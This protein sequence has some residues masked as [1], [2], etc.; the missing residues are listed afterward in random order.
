MAGYDI[1]PRIGIKGESEFN[2]QIKKI[3]NSLKE[4]G[5][6]M[7]ALTAEFES[8]E[9]SQ[10]ALIAKSKV[11]QKQLDAQGQKMAVLQSQYDKEVAKLRELGDEYSRLKAEMGE[12]SAEAGKA[13]AAFNKQAES[14]SKL[15][16]A[17]N[18]TQGFMNKLNNA[19]NKNGQMLNEIETGARDAATGLSTMSDAAQDA[20]SG[21][22]S[23]DSKLDMSNIMQASEVLSG[24]GDTLKEIGSEAIGA[25]TDWDGATAKMQAN[26][27]LTA[28]E[29]EN[30]QGVAQQVFEQGIAS[31]IDTAS[32][33]VMLVKQNFQDLSN[34]D[35]SNLS[36]QL[37]A[38]SERTGTDLQE[39]MRGVDQIMTAF[40]VDGQQAMDLI[41]AGYQQNLNSSGDFMDTL[42]EYAPLFSEAGFSAEQM[43]AVLDSGMENGALNTDKVADAV[44]EL[45]IRFG[46]GTFEQNMGLFSQSTQNMFR[47]WQNGG[48]TVAEVAASI[49]E[50]LKKMTPT[51]QQQALSALSTQ[52]EDLGVDASVALLSASDGF[53]DATGKAN[54]FS[55]ATDS[56]KWQ[57]NLN[58]ITDSL[59]DIGGTVQNTLNPVLEF[60]AGLVEAFSNLPAPV[61]TVLTVL[62]GLVTIFTTL[63]PFISSVLTVIQTLAPIITGTMIPAIGGILSALAPLLPVIAAVVAAVTAAILIFKNWG[64]ITE[65]LSGLW[66]VFKA[67]IS[68][69]WNSIKDTASS[70]W[71]SITSAISN[72]VTTVSQT[73]SN[74]WNNIKTTVS[75]I[76]NNIKDAAVNG[77]RNLVNGIKSVLSGISNTIKGAFDSAISFITSLPG[78]ALGWGRD[79]INGLKNGIMSGVNAIVNA[80]K[81]VANRIR[82]F[83][84]FSRPDEGPLRDYETWM[85]DMLTGMA[86]SVYK[87]LDI[88]QNAA[89]TISGTINSNITDDRNGVMRSAQTSYSSTIV[90]EGDSIILDGKVIG[91]T[92][93][94]YIS[95]GQVARMKARGAFA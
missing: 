15:Q 14:V 94:R 9:N 76:T 78:K 93:E 55:Q 54:E 50:D 36:G 84:H 79:F 73:I 64:T 3:N 77:F 57:G 8:N 20:G 47:E 72:A 6:E 70:V 33:A 37:A 45:Q 40:G 31:S 68:E 7:K 74:I 17:M 30:L 21:L 80:V 62:G 52:F 12:N 39:N 13:E 5:S 82:S 49:G 1:G 34:A 22:E 53:V 69:I 35:L 38:I 4:Y 10:Q 88:I 63:A 46:D 81:N 16:V 92:A 65:F 28:D 32:E 87:N 71:N 85:P 23:I 26:L 89:K 51:E 58:K 43:L 90:V 95:N 83:L 67:K 75:N 44:K 24:V 59:S 19:I 91:K 56:E 61:Q 29:A 27:G 48:A 2:A 11:L 41:A 60:V 25:A 42:N 66:E 86:D 18:E